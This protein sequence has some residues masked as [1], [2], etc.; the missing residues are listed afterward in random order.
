MGGRSGGGGRSSRGRASPSVAKQKLPKAKETL[1][2]LPGVDKAYLARE[3]KKQG[4]SPKKIRDAM[5]AT[6][7]V[8]IVVTKAGKGKIYVSINS[9]MYN[10]QRVLVRTKRGKYIKN[11]F[12]G[13]FNTGTGLGAKIFARQVKMASKLGYSK[14]KTHA[15]GYKDGFFNG[16]TT[17]AKLGYN[18]RISA[19]QKSLLPQQ[20]QGA[21]T[22]H[23]LRK[24]K[25]GM[26][27]WK[28][29]G[30]D[31]QGTFNLAKGS[32]SRKVL[33]AYLRNLRNGG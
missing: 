15:A 2:V 4:L 17:W 14:I 1:R 8:K 27:A 25:G 6:K 13:T 5:G 10:M 32:R 19:S 33:A 18:G 20:H 11:E 24:M 12:F 9:G 26:A 23:Q 21:N 7:G 3:M 30:S 29:H 16:Y 28:E 22:I 31:F